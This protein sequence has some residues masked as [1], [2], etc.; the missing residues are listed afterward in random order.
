MLT[1][2]INDANVEHSFWGYRLKGVELTTSVGSISFTETNYNNNRA[3]CV[4]NRTG[5]HKFRKGGSGVSEWKNVTE[6]HPDVHS[7][8]WYSY[9]ETTEA[10]GTREKLQCCSNASHADDGYI[11]AE[12]VA[13]T[14]PVAI[15]RACC[16]QIPHNSWDNNCCSPREMPATFSEGRDDTTGEPTTF[17]PGR[18][19]S[20]RGTI[21]FYRTVVGASAG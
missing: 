2:H 8:L 17:Q 6:L 16:G 18:N 21:R 4:A 15:N 10:D 3:F 14:E 9:V 20:D 19:F 7:S 5:L 11:W 1:E 13:G 12:I